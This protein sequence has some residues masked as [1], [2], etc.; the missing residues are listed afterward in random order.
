MRTS[1]YSQENTSHQRGA[2]FQG[3]AFLLGIPRITQVYEPYFLPAQR[4]S[5]GL[6][7]QDQGAEPLRAEN[8]RSRRRRRLRGRTDLLQR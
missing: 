7:S 8:R 6:S 5:P 3:E 2:G 1:D 4:A